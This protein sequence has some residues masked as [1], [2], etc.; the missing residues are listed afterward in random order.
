MS[1]TITEK[2]F[3]TL[4]GWQL[5]VAE[6]QIE[7]TAQG[8]Q[9]LSYQVG[10]QPPIIWLSETAEFNPGQSARGGIPICWPWFGAIAR[11]PQTV[12]NMTTAS[13]PFHGLA[14][15]HEWQLV[16]QCTTEHSACL[17]LALDTQTQPLAEWPH[18]AR[19]TLEVLLTAEQLSLKLSTD[20]LGQS[21]LHLSQALHS[22]FS[23]SDIEHVQ[24]TGFENCHYIET[25][26]NWQEK[27]Q[28]GAI[29]FSGETDRIYLQPATTLSIVDNHWHRRIQLTSQHSHSAVVWN[30][31]TKK[32]R[33]LS[34][35]KPSAWQQ[36]LCI[37]TANVWDDC[38]TLTA[39]QNHCL[40]LIISCQPLKG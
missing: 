18:A 29:I 30:P 25:L 34:Q 15:L 35:F 32:A 20:N 26:E 10:Q 1:A 3:N 2:N 8:A 37:E 5:C 17:V 31:W 9:L 19:V 28:S 36:M 4:A 6:A 12:Q 40:D 14:R 39:N 13:A 22:Y 7:I 11:N 33:Q 16:D 38:I 21:T 23:I 24:V 27:T